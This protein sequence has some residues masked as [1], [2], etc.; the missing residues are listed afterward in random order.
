MYICCIKTLTWANDVNGG[1]H[2]ERKELSFAE[3]LVG[4]EKCQQKGVHDDA[5]EVEV[6]GNHD[7]GGHDGIEIFLHR[8][9]RR[10]HRRWGITLD[11]PRYMVIIVTKITHFSSPSRQFLIHSVDGIVGIVARK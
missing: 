9:L 6:S 4:K 8:W 5:L 11:L 1:L 2:D 7:S 10:R 3:L